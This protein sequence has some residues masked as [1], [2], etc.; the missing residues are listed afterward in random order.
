M[1][2]FSIAVE[3]PR[4]HTQN[5]VSMGLFA[6]IEGGSITG[7]DASPTLSPAW[8]LQ[9]RFSLRNLV[10]IRKEAVQDNFKDSLLFNQ[11][12]LRQS[13]SQPWALSN[14]VG[15]NPLLTQAE[16][17][18]LIGHQQCCVGCHPQ[19][20]ASHPDVEVEEGL[21]VSAGK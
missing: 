17:W 16:W 9:N 18:I 1:C 15:W 12:I 7:C 8:Q 13:S 20:P 6:G 5:V 4:C 21:R 11:Q 19:P 2:I 14:L 10:G 3:Q